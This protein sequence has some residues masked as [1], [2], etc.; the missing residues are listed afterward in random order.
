MYII[1]KTGQVYGRYRKKGLN[2]SNYQT[3]ESAQSKR[4]TVRSSSSMNFFL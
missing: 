4:F 1:S 3:F 2:F